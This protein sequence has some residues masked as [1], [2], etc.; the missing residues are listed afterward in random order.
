M[1]MGATA[2]NPDSTLTMMLF[3]PLTHYELID[4]P[5]QSK[6]LFGAQS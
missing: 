3:N 5:K 1:G 2:S 4:L 6:K